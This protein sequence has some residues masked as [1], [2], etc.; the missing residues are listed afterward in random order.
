MAVGAE[1][2]HQTVH[3]ID[4]VTFSVQ[5]GSRALKRSMSCDERPRKVACVPQWNRDSIL[6]PHRS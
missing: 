6:R 3:F 4:V 5:C 1:A 2:H